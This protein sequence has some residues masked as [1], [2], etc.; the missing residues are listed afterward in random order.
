MDQILVIVE[1]PAKAKTIKKYLGKGYKVKASVGHIRDLPKKELGIDL[2]KDFEPK[3]VND[4]SKSKIIKELRDTAGKSSEILL[5]TDMDREG[6]AIA[7]HLNEILKKTGVP[8]KRI[9]FNEITA[10]AIKEAVENPRDLDMNKVNA[11]QAR[12]ILD[13]LVGYLV[14]P[15]LWKVFYRGLSAGRVQSVGLR[16]LCERENLIRDFKPQ[17]YWTVDGVLKTAEGAEFPARLF[18]IDG[19]TPEIPS[20]EIAE[21]ILSDIRTG[22]LFVDKVVEKDKNRNPQPPFITSTLQREAASRLGFSAKKTMV[23][24]QQLYEG[25]TIGEEGSVGL[26]SYMRT[27]STRISTDAFQQ[28][29][30]FIEEKYGSSFVFQGKRG[31][32]KLKGSQD[33]HEAIRPTDSFKTPENVAP[34][35]EKDQ[36][37]LYSLIWMRFLASIAAPAVYSTR[38]ADIK[39]GERYLLRANGRKIKSEGFLAIFPDRKKEEDSWIPDMESGEELFI[40]DFD[41]TQKFTEA[42]ARFTEASLIKELEDKGIGRPSTYASIISI[43][44][45]RDYAVREGKSL[46][47]TELGEVVWRSLSAIFNDIF[48]IDFTARM[49]DEL[50][51]VEES[52]DK[53]QDAVRYFYEPLSADLEQ[54]KGK[55]AEYKKMFQEETEEKCEKCGKKLIR[56]WSRNGIFLACP[57]YPE[58]KFAKSVEE[59][60]KL[61]KQCPKCGGELKYKSGRFGRF[62]ACSN[63]PECKYTETVTLGIPCPEDGCD[64][65]IAEKKTRRGKVFY[66][67][68]RYPDC[69][70]ASWDKPTDKKCPECGEAFLVQKTSKKKGEYLKCP[71]CKSEVDI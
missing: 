13:R 62:I 39:S 30:A 10:N 37:A 9:I 48:E 15:A 59:E 22:K 7:W 65:K 64:G 8:S 4:R 11:Q 36:L 52:L 3:Y 5:A 70:F 45:S 55:Q 6:E 29:K 50:D 60:E 57:G 16:L 20:G 31:Y 14:S 28:G 54:F 23:V 58:C 19:N 68:S 53:W 27:D 25:L 71:A 41:G 26:I 12:R 46:K 33:A 66:G 63:Y 32:K 24:A 1:S 47:P 43:I 56:K 18:K 69:K 17:E 21:Q 67:C 44:L 2:D 35:L 49:E 51:K 42:P 61:D 38:E 40:K 34:Y